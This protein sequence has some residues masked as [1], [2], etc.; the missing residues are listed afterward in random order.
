[1]QLQ[2]S[3]TWFVRPCSE[4]ADWES[5][6]P[7]LAVGKE[8][9]IEQG[10]GGARL[11]IDCSAG[12]LLL[13]NTRAWWHRTEINVQEGSG[14]SVSYARD[15]YLDGRAPGK[16]A[17]AAGCTTDDADIKTNDSTLDPRMLARKVFKAGDV[18]LEEDELPD[19]DLP[20]AADPNCSMT[21]LDDGSEALVAL[22]RIRKDEP[23]TL[24]LGD[25]SDADGYELW[26]LD[27]E[28]GEM[29]HVEEDA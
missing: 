27:P 8:G 19:D 5:A 3:K 2:G 7:E 10:R 1:V 21:E 24:G 23:L 16:G 29:L 28:T 20:R 11:C 17:V 4:A 22:R 6:P 25:E 9:V 15:F 14:L 26:E 12:D 13:I 18:V